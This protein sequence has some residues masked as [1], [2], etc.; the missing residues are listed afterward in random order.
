MARPL[1]RLQAIPLDHKVP[2]LTWTLF[3]G[4][5]SESEVQERSFVAGSSIVVRVQNMGVFVKITISDGVGEASELMLTGQVL[6]IQAGGLGERI[7][8]RI[9]VKAENQTNK[10]TAFGAPLSV[11]VSVVTVASTRPIPSFPRPPK[12]VPPP[13]APPTP[14]RFHTVKPNEYLRKIAEIYYHDPNKWKVIYDANKTIIGPNPN[15]IFAGQKLRV[16]F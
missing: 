7:P 5:N 4:H 13:P 11:F 16:P 1:P 6:I 3:N 2:V 9:K 12:V 8:Y 15:L 14:G 10:L